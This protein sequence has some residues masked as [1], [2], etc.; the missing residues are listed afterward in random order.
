MGRILG[1]LDPSNVMRSSDAAK[2]VAAKGS[3]SA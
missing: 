3:S 1:A 2:T